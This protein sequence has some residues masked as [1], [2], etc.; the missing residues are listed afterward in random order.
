MSTM[1]VLKDDGGSKAAPQQEPQPVRE[2]VPIPPPWPPYGPCYDPYHL[3][4]EIVARFELQG[5]L[6]PETTPKDIEG[7]LNAC[8]S[9]LASL[10]IEPVSVSPTVARRVVL[11]VVAA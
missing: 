2:G 11:S 3:L 6:P 9:L 10:G 1:I 7:A 5:Q 8:R 4:G